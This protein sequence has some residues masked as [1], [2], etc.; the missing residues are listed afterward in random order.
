MPEGGP[1]LAVSGRVPGI[2]GLTKSA[3]DTRLFGA[4]PFLYFFCLCFLFS[5]SPDQ[6]LRIDLVVRHFL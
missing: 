1:D 5:F 2:E 6:V 3:L 4:L